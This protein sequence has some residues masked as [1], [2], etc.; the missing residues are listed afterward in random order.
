MPVV[1]SVETDR[2]VVALTFDDGPKNPETERLLD[3]FDDANAHATFFVRGG[4]LTDDAEGLVTRAFAAGHEI[5]N[6]T[7]SHLWLEGAGRVVAER[8]ILR[9][10][11][12]LT[13]L[14]GVEPMVI[15]PPYGVGL[16]L[17]DEIA[18]QL[19]YRATVHWSVHATDW[20]CPPA[21][22][23]VE[24]IL[25]GVRPGAI[26]L[27]HDGCSPDRLWQSRMAT[28]D[29]TRTLIPAIRERG[30]ELVTVSQLLESM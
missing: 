26:V 22:T 7:H 30:F 17:V 29:A 14:V 6:H 18:T 23:I 2:N 11:H 27:L 20:E 24:R 13:G 12:D 16:E 5:G 10:H 19:G 21:D 28:V 8:E 4:A 3:V 1:H 15:R 9:T 25:A